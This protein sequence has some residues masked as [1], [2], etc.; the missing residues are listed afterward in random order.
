MFSLGRGITATMRGNHHG[1]EP[2]EC[3]KRN[4]AMGWTVDLHHVFD[5]PF[6]MVEIQRDVIE[7]FL[8]AREFCVLN[9]DEYYE[10]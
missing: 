5:R 6:F 9:F 1:H 2:P 8:S 10:C 3:Y 4:A 7:C